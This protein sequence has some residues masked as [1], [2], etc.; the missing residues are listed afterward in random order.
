MLERRLRALAAF[1]LRHRRLVLALWL[2]PLPALI[3][4]YLEVNGVLKSIIGS[5]EQAQSSIVSHKLAHDFPG[6]SQFL[7]V[8]TFHHDRETV[9]DATY[10]KSVEHICRA[11]ARVKCVSKVD[12]YPDIPLRTLF[13]SSDDH[14][15]MALVDIGV[16]VN[17]YTQAEACV[18]SIRKAIA[19]ARGDMPLRDLEVLL[20]GTP[21]VNLDIGKIV[22]HDSR[23]SE[24][25]VVAFSLFLLIWMF[26]SAAAAFLPL[27]TAA[28]A[29]ML[30]LSGIY[31][32]GSWWAMSIYVATVATMTG[33]A[34]GLDY[35]LLYVTRFK[36]ELDG[37]A[38]PEE[39]LCTTAATAGK[40]ILGS[41]T[42]V[43]IGFSGLFIPH[44]G[45]ARS[46][47]LSGVLIVLCTLL[48]T[49]TLLPVLL[50]YWRPLM[51]WPRWRWFRASHAAVDRFWGRWGQLVLARRWVP[52]VGAAL[53]VGLCAPHLRELR[54]KNPRHE[55]IPTTVESRRGVDRL[56]EV[57]GEGRIYPIT[58]LV[59]ITDGGTWKDRARQKRL[60]ALIKQLRTWPNISDI[61]SAD[62]TMRLSFTVLG[63]RIGMGFAEG[64][65]RAFISADWKT[66]SLDVYARNVDD[67]ILGQLVLK[68]RKRLP[69]A[70]A[71]DP[72]LKVW[73]GGRPAMSW[74]TLTMLVDSLSLMVPVVV[75]CAF[76]LMAFFFRSVLIPLK[77]V[78]L[79]ALSM[80]TTYGILVLVF[81]HGYGLSW[82]G[83]DGPAPGALSL[84]TPVVMFCVLFGV[85]MDYE[86]FLVSRIQEAWRRRGGGPDL[87]PAQAEAIHQ[88][89]IHEGLARTG[90]IITNAALIMVLTFT[91]FVA[92][93]LLPMKE[94]GFALALAVF[95]DATLVRMMLVPLALRLLGRFTWWWPRSRSTR[96][97]EP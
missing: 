7:S 30:C 69:K 4:G 52:L 83:Y 22:E 11:I 97:A 37:G 42:L 3:Y 18:V 56:I 20:T 82:L 24:I 27:I 59:Q 71:A 39:A 28:M 50:W 21:A 84:A 38:D 79:N 23:R 94:M 60:L 67:E 81:Q 64:F 6:L 31:L 88:E 66:A 33:L 85:S 76:V 40:A 32:I 80:S 1:L 62:L 45:F 35:A 53:I 73:V 9:D 44:L 13:V 90:G 93:S 55:I 10:A 12:K 95:L 17:A 74:E 29:V 41:G 49:L 70:L 68:L 19:Q 77:A 8:A 5:N 15:A 87:E 78:L 43:M 46:V 63:Q 25:I 34:L 14:T 92:G 51:G 75:I 16:P 89:A 36:E 91:A 65:A 72:G 48:A 86:V 2:V 47:A 26:R 58:L 96:S 57:A 54:V 61:W